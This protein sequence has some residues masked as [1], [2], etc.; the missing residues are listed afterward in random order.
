MLDI[1][2]DFRNLKPTLRGWAKGGIMKK[3]QHYERIIYLYDTEEEKYSHS[4]EMQKQGYIDTERYG[5]TI[6]NP[7]NGEYESKI[8][9]LYEKFHH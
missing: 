1:R 2:I 6:R 5:M 7:E 8:C 4:K 9:G 3:Y